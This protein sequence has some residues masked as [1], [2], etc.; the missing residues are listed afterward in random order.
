MLLVFVSCLRVVDVEK[1]A[2]SCRERERAWFKTEAGEE[3]ILAGVVGRWK[4]G[5]DERGA[6]ANAGASR[7]GA[8]V[9]VAAG[10][11][12]ASALLNGYLVK[13]VRLRCR[14]DMYA[15]GHASTFQIDV[16]LL[17]KQN[18]GSG[19]SLTIL[20]TGEVVA[21]AVGYS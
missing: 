15:G 21:S 16:A 17:G 3:G 14:M 6:D 1:W 12:V 11:L 18:A 4:R 5:S 8:N 20:P 7:R 19:G 2:D 10:T 9:F 13:A